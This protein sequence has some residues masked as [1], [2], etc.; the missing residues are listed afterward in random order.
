MKNT[1][2]YRIRI[3]AALLSAIFGVG[4]FVADFRPF[5]VT[6]LVFAVVWLVA[7]FTL[8]N[9]VVSGAHSTKGRHNR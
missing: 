3:I 4:G 7:V 8:A 2:L 1:M 5:F 6:A 9:R